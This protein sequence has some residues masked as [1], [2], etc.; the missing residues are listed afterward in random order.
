MF[1]LGYRAMLTAVL[2]TTVGEVRW[3]IHVASNLMDVAKQMFCL[4]LFPKNLGVGEVQKSLS[5][6]L[7]T[8]FQL[9]LYALD[10]ALPFWKMS[11]C[12][13]RQ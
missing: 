7:T 2:L 1:L 11:L 10:I 4:V 3:R 6:A 13:G 12:R 5:R 8:H 9:K